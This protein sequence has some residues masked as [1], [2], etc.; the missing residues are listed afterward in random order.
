MTEMCFISSTSDET[1]FRIQTHRVPNH[2]GY[3]ITFITHDDQYEQAMLAQIF[4]VT[5][6]LMEKH[7]KVEILIDHVPYFK[8]QILI[9]E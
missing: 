4:D 7:T 6:K 5:K 3:A 2:R 8:A 1:A 9:F